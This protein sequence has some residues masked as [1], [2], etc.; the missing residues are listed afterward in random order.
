MTLPA[1]FQF[2]GLSVGLLQV[3]PSAGRSSWRLCDSNGSE[4]PQAEGCSIASAPG[5]AC[6]PDLQCHTMW[7]Y[8]AIK[9]FPSTM[10]QQYTESWMLQDCM[11]ASSKEAI[12]KAHPVLIPATAAS[13]ND[14]MPQIREAALQL[15]TTFAIRAGSMKPIDR[16]GTPYAHCFV[17]KECA[18]HAHRLKEYATARTLLLSSLRYC[19]L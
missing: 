14:A 2:A 15:L 6:N 8:A 10:M 7:R 12:A 18:S 5:V 19:P 3:L 13:A 1:S 9:N 4:E 16:V 17:G 11:D